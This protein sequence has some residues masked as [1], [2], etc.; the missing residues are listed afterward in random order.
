[1]ATACWLHD[2]HESVDAA[3]SEVLAP[4][5]GLSEEAP[6][7]TISSEETTQTMAHALGDVLRLIISQRVALPGDVLRLH[8][9]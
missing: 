9:W 1:M 3:H 2:V 7:F 6:E 4:R 5:K 8:S